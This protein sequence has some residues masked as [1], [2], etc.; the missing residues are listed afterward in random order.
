MKKRYIAC[1]DGLTKEQSEKILAFI[2]ENDLSW[3]HW[4][5]DTWFI[6]DHKGDFDASQIRDAVKKI[7][8][9]ERLVIIEI[10]KNNDT[11]SGVRANDPE[12][13]MFKW[14]HEVW[15]N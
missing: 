3:W 15:K 7:I 2:R 6:V 13:K 11:W 4:L 9:N 10:N 14:F 8:P 5:G 1:F 12:E